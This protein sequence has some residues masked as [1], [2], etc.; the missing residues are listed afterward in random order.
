MDDCERKRSDR[1]EID[2]RKRLNKYERYAM[3]K[4]ATVD[5]SEER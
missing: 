5:Y 1:Y 2:N 3:L 4:L